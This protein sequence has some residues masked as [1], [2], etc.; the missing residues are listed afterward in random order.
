MLGYAGAPMPPE[1]MRQAYER[2]T[3]NLVQYY[4][5]VEAIPPVTVL[6]RRSC[7]RAGSPG[8]PEL[9]ASAGRPALG[10]EI[11]RRRRGRHAR[12]RRA[13]SAR[14]SR[15]A[16]TSWPATGTPT[17]ASDLA[18]S[19]VDGWLHTGD[20]GRID[21]EGQLWLVD[22]KGDMIISGGY[23]IYP[24][25]VE[26]VVAEVPGVAEVAVVG[27]TDRGLGPARG[28]TRVRAA[29]AQRR[30]EAGARALPGPAGGVQEA[31]G[32]ARRGLL[33]AQLDREDRQEGAASAAG[34]RGGAM[35]RPDPVL[36]SDYAPPAPSIR[37]STPTRVASR[38][39]RSRGSWAS[40]PASAS[41]GSPTSGS[42]RCSTPARPGFSVALDL[43]TQMGIDSD[44][45][46]AAGE[47]GRVGV[48]ID[49]LA[50]IEILMDGIPL[51]Q[52][53]QVR[54]TANSIG[55]IWAALFVA[56]AEKRDV[57]PDTF[58]HVHPERRA[59]GVHRARHADLPA[60]GV[61]R[62]WRSTR[63]EY[64]AQH[65]PN[66]T[67]LAMSGY[68]I[69]ESGA[70]ADAGDRLH[71]RQRPRLPRRVRPAWRGDRPGRADAVHVPGDHHGLPAG[72]GEVP[73]R[74]AGVGTA[75]ARART[76]PRTRAR[77]SCGSSPSPPARRSPRSNR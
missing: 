22:R 68:H 46:R 57:D 7:T 49:S 6:D 10:V 48:A 58:G 50:D 67:P 40:T 45:P 43:P 70:S 33:P 63:I 39:S 54:T 42:G 59:Q 44:D 41:P 75:H 18:K 32:G 69:R 34:S 36:R 19:V 30:A 53:S 38:P 65:V 20:L 37:A 35:R 47:V 17:V 77:S 16:T 25:E 29:G 61:A 28:R 72:G 4:G 51:E 21:D 52:I 71:V 5:L 2:L 1:Q 27:V 3:P 13:R 12:C 23:N 11:A 15:A 56:L 31:E 66:W 8:E 9:L 26:N 76:A 60:G 62:R 73:R 14:S 74:A 64:C 24:R 55:Y